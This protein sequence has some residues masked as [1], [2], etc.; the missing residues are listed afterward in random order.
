MRQLSLFILTILFSVC[1]S[2]AQGQGRVFFDK[3][4]IASNEGSA[5]YYREKA[6]EESNYKSF[7]ANG[8][9]IF[10][11]GKMSYASVSNEQQNKY[12]DKC[13]WYWKNGKTKAIRTFNSEGKEHGTSTLFYESGKIWKEIEYNNGVIVNNTYKEFTEDGQ[14]NKIFEEDFDN[15]FNDWDLYNS[16]KSYSVIQNGMLELMSYTKEGTSR[17]IN[18]PIQSSEFT[19]EASIDIEKMKDGEKAGIIFGFKD[20]NNYCYYFITNNSIFIGLMYEGVSSIKANGMYCDVIKKKGS[21]NLKIISTGDKYIYSVNGE[22]QYKTDKFRNFGNNIGFMLTGKNQIK[23][24]N[25]IIKEINYRGASSGSASNNNSDQNVKSYGSGLVISTNGYILTNWHV[26]ENSNKIVVEVNQNGISGSFDATLVQK[27]VDNDLAIIKIT[28]DRYKPLDKLQYSFK[29]GGGVDVGASVFTIGYPLALSGM[30]REAKFTD[31]KIS[32]K[33]GYN[34]AINTYQTTVPVQ[35]GNS[36]GPLF[37]E[38]GQLVGVMN[39]KFKNADNVSYAIKLGYVRNLMELL[40][41]EPAMP[42]NNSISELSLEEKV[43]L[44]SSYVVLI[45]IK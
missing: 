14:A 24:D 33:T 12:L 27:D 43:K 8:G 45:K 31:G 29:R 40:P 7:Y 3:A 18:I 21:N 44:L 9:N 15:N 28:D 17:F 35:P 4:G 11:E 26:V 41:D 36:G 34:N 23:V 39:A 32:S 2:F 1:N 38:Q 22:I 6:S 13:T 42:E 19:L 16:D 25:L 37:N 20:W 10:F 30:G 5:F